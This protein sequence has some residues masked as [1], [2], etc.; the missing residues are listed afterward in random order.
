MWLLGYFRCCYE[1][2]APEGMYSDLVVPWQ[3]GF[4]LPYHTCRKLN[5]LNVTEASAEAG[6]F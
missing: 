3:Q 2:G 1:G 5:T 4:S 6:A